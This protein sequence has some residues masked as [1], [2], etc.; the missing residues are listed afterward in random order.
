VT[1]GDVSRIFPLFLLTGKSVMWFGKPINASF[2]QTRSRSREAG[3]AMKRVVGVFLAVLL[4]VMLLTV[5][6]SSRQAWAEPSQGWSKTYGGTSTDW[7]FVLVQTVDGGYAIAGYTD[8][9]GAGSNDFCLVKTDAAGNAQWNRT[10]GGTDDDHALALVQT[11]D[12]G[13]ALAGYTDSFGAGNS[14]F[15]LVKTDADGVVPEFPSSMILVAFMVTVT[16]TA[17]LTKRKHRARLARG[18]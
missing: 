3:V 7:V 11:V 6:L 5:L 8:S 16:L 10:Y 1:S 2:K 14:D 13:Y 15:W 4:S 9:F 17:V 12:G 18:F